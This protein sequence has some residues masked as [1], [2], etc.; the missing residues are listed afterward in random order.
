MRGGAGTLSHQQVC[1]RP[2]QL[3]QALQVA[4]Q[5]SKVQKKKDA[6][7][8]P[9]L[10]DPAAQQGLSATRDA[11]AMTS[12]HREGTTL[13]VE[14][15]GPAPGPQQEVSSTSMS[16]LFDHHRRHYLACGSDYRMGCRV[17]QML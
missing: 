1:G 2:L 11:E 10:P 13:L 9:A 6:G 5:V 14:Y 3:H 16:T 8:T 12:S 15:P 4:V 7:K 17:L